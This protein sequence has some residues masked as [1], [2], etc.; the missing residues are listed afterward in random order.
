MS[1]VANFSLMQE[2][3]TLYENLLNCDELT[4]PTIE[5]FYYDIKGSDYSKLSFEKFISL[6]SIEHLSIKIEE[7]FKMKL[8]ELKNYVCEIPLELI[9]TGSWNDEDVLAFQEFINA[10]IKLIEPLLK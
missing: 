4:T 7:F 9:G 1:H 3:K 6:C 2:F 5:D 10:R 8:E